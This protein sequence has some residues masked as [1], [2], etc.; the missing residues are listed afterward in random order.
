MLYQ[1]QKPKHK[2]RIHHVNIGAFSQRFFHSV[3]QVSEGITSAFGRDS[4]DRAGIVGDYG[5]I[6]IFDLNPPVDLPFCG[7][8][9]CG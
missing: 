3:R 8:L 1:V 2:T 6:K 5:H 4:N 9:G 7:V